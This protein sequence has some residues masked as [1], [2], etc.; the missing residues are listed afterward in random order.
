MQQFN[1]SASATSATTGRHR[2]LPAM[3]AAYEEPGERSA[4]PIYDS[5]CAEY[6]RLFRAVPGERQGEEALR[7]RGFAAL[8]WLGATYGTRPDGRG[9]AARHALPAGSSEP[10]HDAERSERAE[11]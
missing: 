2:S 3:R 6:R 8:S 7:F 9:P 1:V 5:L 11:R 4:T 10:G